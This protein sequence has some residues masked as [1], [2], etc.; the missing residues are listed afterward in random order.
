MQKREGGDTRMTEQDHEVVNYTRSRVKNKT[1]LTNLM[2]ISRI[3]GNY[4]T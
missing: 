3:E 4:G 2:K 1:K